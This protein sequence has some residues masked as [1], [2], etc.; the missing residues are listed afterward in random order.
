[1]FAARLRLKSEDLNLRKH[2]DERL[3]AAQEQRVEEILIQLGLK[4]CADTRV[5]N[6]KTSGISGGEKKRLNIACEL[7]SN[8]GVLLLDEPTRC[9]ILSRIFFVFNCSPLI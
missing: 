5:G 7:L 1:V 3:L 6:G 4:H 9:V 2:D 8:P